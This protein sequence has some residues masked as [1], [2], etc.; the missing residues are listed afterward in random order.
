[1]TT[2]VPS[3]GTRRAKATRAPEDASVRVGVLTA[4]PALLRSLGVDPAAA[5]AEAGLPPALLDNSDNLVAYRARARLLSVCAAKTRCGHFG[6]LL[7]QQGR[8]SHFELVG[9]L[10][11][12]SPDVGTALRNFER[13]LHL[14]VRGAAPRLSVRGEMAVLGYD[15]QERDIEGRDQVEDAAMAVAFNILRSLC[16]SEWK[17][18][19]AHFAHRKPND[20]RPFARFFRAPLRF[21]T[22]ETGIQFSTAC[23][24][25]P[26]PAADADLRRLLQRQVDA[27]D[28]GPGASLPDRV[29]GVL[30]TAILTG[31]GAVEDIAPMFSMH[32]RT[33]HR[34]LAEFGVTFKDLADEIRF[35]IARRM[36]E[37]SAM[38]ITQ[39]ADALDYA[40]ASAFTRAFRRWTKTTPAAWRDAVVAATIRRRARPPAVVR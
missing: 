36:L 23:L 13:Y 8:L 2:Y 26:L 18:S 40:D 19:E 32:S 10:V 16:G 25:H 22:L 39:I 14:H 28:L 11:Q 29:K 1:M 27:L 6:L 3:R 21:D 31:H 24:A 35:E 30:R 7:G 17:P 5:L 9:F 12:N 4:A 33:L 15:I 38:P 37:G 20:T 34:R